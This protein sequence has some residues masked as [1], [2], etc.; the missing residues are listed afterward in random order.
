MSKRQILVLLGVWVGVFLFLGLPSGWLEILGVITG[1]SLI[2]LA[3]S[4][5][6]EPVRM[7]NIDNTFVE[8]RNDVVANTQPEIQPE[9]A[10]STEEVVSQE[11]EPVVQNDNSNL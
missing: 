9:E 11:S 4:L 2:A 1:I 6:S 7:S 5:G 3:Y 8:H 10:V